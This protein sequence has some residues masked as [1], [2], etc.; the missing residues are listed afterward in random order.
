MKVFMLMKRIGYSG[1]A[2]MFKWLITTLSKVDGI[3]VVVFTFM[4]SAEGMTLPS[5]VKWIDRD[6]KKNGFLSRLSAIRKTIKQENP[7]ACIS[8]LLDANILNI[9]ACLGLSTKSVVCERL[10]PFM[11]GYYKTDILK[12]LFS[13]AD[14]A[15]FQLKKVGEYYS[16]I[17]KHTAVIPN[18]IISSFNEEIEPFEKR[19]KVIINLAR[20]DIRQKRQ[21]L[22]IKAFALFAEKYPDYKLYLWGS[23][24]DKGRL[25][26]LAKQMGVEDKVCLPGVTN[27][28]KN[29]IKKARLY[30]FASDS[31]GIPNSIIEAM[32][33]G[34]PCVATK[35]SPGGA[36]LL[37]SDGQNGC[38]VDRGDYKAMADKLIWLAENPALADEIGRRARSIS[39]R[40]S[41]EDI[42][43]LWVKYLHEL[44]K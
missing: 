11:K 27:E 31:E 4:P 39:T 2:K 18:P 12:P 28:S 19:D 42:S 7:D 37:I 3:E 33:V 25:L 16:N 26:A 23:G 41:E 10:D 9:L 1:A 20:L 38:L 15:V 24:P 22:L 30:A 14:G 34:L 43:A 32:Q 40:F 44:C 5:N 29:V 36:E 21:D 13:L 6:M 35:C 17:K 8:F